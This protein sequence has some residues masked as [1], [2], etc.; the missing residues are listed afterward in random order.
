[1]L[2]SSGGGPSPVGAN[3][4]NGYN[5]DGARVYPYST[6]LAI[7]PPSEYS[8]Y[9]GGAANLPVT[10]PVSALSGTTGLPSSSN[11]VANAIA[12]PFG[13]HGVIIPVIVG[14]VFAVGFM[15]WVHYSEKKR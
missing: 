8:Y 3:I 2:R 9:I 1:M 7:K 13:T 5:V 15:H 12:N 10:P 6:S 11:G 14:L 4:Q